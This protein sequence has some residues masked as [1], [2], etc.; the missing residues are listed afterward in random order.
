MNSSRHVDASAYNTLRD[1][2][3]PLHWA[4][5]MESVY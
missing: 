5:F 1:P 4:G 3:N 2:G